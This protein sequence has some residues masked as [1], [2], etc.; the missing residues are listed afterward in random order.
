MTSIIIGTISG[1]ISGLISWFGANI[2]GPAILAVRSAREDAITITREHAFDALR[3]GSPQDDRVKQAEEAFGKAAQKL[4]II[5]ITQ[6][7]LARLYC[8]FCGWDL[9]TASELLSEAAGG[10][11]IPGII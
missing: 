11:D 9:R 4:G 8:R 3:H 10:T 6:P 1:I 7:P 2:V 5:A